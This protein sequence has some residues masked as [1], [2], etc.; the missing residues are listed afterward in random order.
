MPQ[1]A[2]LRIVKD[3]CARARCGRVKVKLMPCACSHKGVSEG[4]VDRNC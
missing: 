2:R 1:F 3:A 4:T